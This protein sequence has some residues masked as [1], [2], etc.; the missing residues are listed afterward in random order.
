MIVRIEQKARPCPGVERAISMTEE[1]LRRGEVLYAVGRLIHNEREVA[2]LGEM[3]LRRMALEELMVLG[4]AGELRETQFLVRTHG[5][6]VE[7]IER[8]RKAGMSIVDATCSI[9]RHSQD[10]IE[11]HVRE[12]YGII[13][14]GKAE[15][16]EVKG[17]LGRTRGCGVVVSRP[18]DIE[19]NDFEDRTLLLA[20]TTVDPKWFQEVGRKLSARLEGLKIVDTTCRFIRNRQ[21]DIRGFAVE[22]DVIVLVGGE[23]SSNCELLHATVLEENPQAYK[24]AGPESVD[25]AW[26]RT[27]GCIG[28]T[29][30]ASTPRWQLD[31]MRSYLDNHGLKENPKGLKNSKGGKR[32]WWKRTNKN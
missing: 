18:E 22:N 13:I 21:N 30:G 16:A 14:V 11:Q 2:R 25:P 28:V 7:V 3:G 29:G 10:L 32:S 20:Q 6:P 8:V 1:M 5:E 9:V 27:A 17:L 19:T 26:F 31:E 24:V 12:G 23:R 15:H 4:D